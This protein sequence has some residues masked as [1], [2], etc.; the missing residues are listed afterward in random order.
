MKMNNTQK[1]ALKR[2]RTLELLSGEI[3]TKYPAG[4]KIQFTGSCNKGEEPVTVSCSWYDKV[5]GKKPLKN[6][7][8]KPPEWQNIPYEE[9]E[10]ISKLFDDCSFLIIQ[11]V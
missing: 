9:A 8:D 4:S 3:K 1:K 10:K 2:K 6:F 7:V 11:Y 5:G